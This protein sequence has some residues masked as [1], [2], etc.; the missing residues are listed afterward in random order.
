MSGTAA[1]VAL[2]RREVYLPVDLLVQ[3]LYLRG[4]EIL[5]VL[6]EA[7]SSCVQQV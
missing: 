3:P 7:P 6:Q 1:V 4:L 2:R 5:L